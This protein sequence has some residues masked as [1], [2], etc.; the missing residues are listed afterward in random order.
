MSQ[1]L[2]LTV[3]RYVCVHILRMLKT[4]AVL[5]IVIAVYLVMNVNQITYFVHIGINFHIFIQT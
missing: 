5:L 1:Q 4:C 3:S 2:I